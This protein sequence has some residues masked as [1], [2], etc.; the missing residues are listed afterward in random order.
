MKINFIEEN[1]FEKGDNFDP[2]QKNILLFSF[3]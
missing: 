2:E 1:A 3:S